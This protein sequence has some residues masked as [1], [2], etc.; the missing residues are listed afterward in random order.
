MRI[1]WKHIKT[2][3]SVLAGQCVFRFQRENVVFSGFGGK[4]VNAFL[5]FCGFGGKCVFGVLAGKM[6]F[7]PVLAG[8]AFLRFWRENVC[9]GFCG[10]MLFYGFDGKVRFYRFGL[11][12]WFYWFGRKVCFYG[13][14]RFTFFAETHYRFQRKNVFFSFG[15]K[16]HFLV[17]AEKCSCKKKIEFLV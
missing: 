12:V 4:C 3:F 16:I 7:F 1:V 8:N 9:S 6:Q 11:K 15:G 13:N 14:M 2:A 5:R 17:L 10:K